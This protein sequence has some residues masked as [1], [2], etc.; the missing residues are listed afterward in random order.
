MDKLDHIDWAIITLLNEDGRMPSVEIERRL[1]NIS[2]RTVTNRIESLILKGIINIRAV[3]NP[4]KVGYGVMAEVLIETEPGRLRQVAERTALFPQVSYVACATGET[5]VI[6]SLR[7]RNIEEL[8]S[9]I[10]EDLGKVTGVRNT[11]SY[12]L[13]LM[14]KD[15]ATWLPQNPFDDTLGADSVVPLLS[16]SD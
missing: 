14:I 16:Q 9:F 13:P 8:F 12:L 15:F 7:A 3:V 1:G 10:T 4:E 6:I 11:Q 2:A 5:D